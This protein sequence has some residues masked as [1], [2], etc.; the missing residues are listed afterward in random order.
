MFDAGFLN[1][2]S[3][4]LGAA[5]WIL[6]VVGLMLLMV[7]NNTKWIA[8]SFASITACA[9]SLF[10][11]ISYNN[12]LVDIGD[13]GALMDTSGAVAFVSSVLLIGTLFLNAITIVVYYKRKAY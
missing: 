12:Y 2:A 10:F 5:A 11:Q 3:L 9:I 13:F 8:L 1:L 7:K 4:V 6:P